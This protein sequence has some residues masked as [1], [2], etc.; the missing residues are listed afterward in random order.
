M[1]E[2][3]SSADDE[4]FLDALHEEV[5]ERLA[6][7]LPVDRDAIRARRPALGARIDD[8]VAL[9]CGVALTREPRSLRVAGYSIEGE[10]GRGAMGTVFLARQ[11]TLGRRVALKVLPTWAS[12]SES[13][14]QRFLQEARA[15]ARV[16]HPNVVA[17]HDVIDDGTVHAYAM[18]WI[19]GATLAGVIERLRA[20]GPEASIEDAAAVL[21]ADPARLGATLAVFLARVGAALAR[22]LAT[23]HAAGLLHRDVKPSNVLLRSD[24]APLLSDFGLVRDSETDGLT[25]TGQFLGTVAFASPEQLR[26]DA[27]RVDE[28]SDVYSLGVTLYEALARQLPYPGRSP[29]EVLGRIERGPAALLRRAGA[30]V[31]RDLETIVA[32]AIDP[33]PDRRYGSAADL[34]DDLERLLRLEPIRARPEGWLRRV[35]RVARRDR[36]ALAAAALAAALTLALAGLAAKSWL[37]RLAVPGRVASHVRSARLELLDPRYLFEVWGVIHGGWL[38]ARS[39]LADEGAARAIA[40]YEAALALDPDHDAARLERDLVRASRALDDPGAD[41]AAL[42]PPVAA[43]ARRWAAGELGRS[44]SLEGLA[45]SEVRALGVLAYLSGLVDVS[46]QALDTLDPVAHPDPLVDGL[47]GQVLVEAGGAAAAYPRCLRAAAA[48]PEAGFLAS[49]AAEAALASGDR[50]AARRLLD[51][52][53]RAAIAPDGRVHERRRLDLLWAEGDAEAAVA[54]YERMLR[55]GRSTPELFVRLAR[56]HES[57]GEREAAMRRAVEAH[58][59]SPSYPPLRALLDRV[60]GAWWS[61]EPPLAR[62]ALAASAIEGR[63]DARSISFAELARWLGPPPDPP[64]S[65]APPP[66]RRA[67]DLVAAPPWAP[68]ADAGAASRDG[69]FDDLPL[70]ETAARVSAAERGETLRADAWRALW[71]ETRTGRALAASLAAAG[72]IPRGPPQPPEGP[73]PADRMRE[74]A[75]TPGFEGVLLPAGDS[76]GDGIDELWTVHRRVGDAGREIR[77]TSLDGASARAGFAAALSASAGPV[78]LA[79]A[80]LD[81]DGALD[82]VAGERDA[83]EAGLDAGSV[84]CFSGRTGERLWRRTGAGA[85]TRL[86]LA[87]T[88]VGDVDGDGVPEIAVSSASTGGTGLVEILS[89]RDGSRL[90]ALSG[91]SS[92]SGFGAALCGPGDVDG[93]G[94]GDLA[95]SAPSEPVDGL[96]RGRV[97]V[98]SARDGKVLSVFARRDGPPGQLGH[99]LSA[100]GDVDGDGRGDVAVG[101]PGAIAGDGVCVV[102][103]RGEL[104]A[105]VRAGPRD[106]GL[107]SAIALSESDAGPALAVSAP[108]ADRPW[109][110]DAGLVLLVDRRSGRPIERAMGGAPGTRLGEGLAAIRVDAGERVLVLG[111]RTSDG[112]KGLWSW[113]PAR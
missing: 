75:V 22:A 45:P 24:G 43:V 84:A 55:E 105:T 78:R 97:R 65:A 3:G 85:D 100:V 15:L 42:P 109:A 36:R 30:R 46:I 102:S 26:G 51:A 9:A 34:A 33:D 11:E 88:V 52:A 48:F 77:V 96:P 63:G 86:G 71:R 80:D 2:A 62:F 93:D 101:A 67:W 60:S 72:W 69:E 5:L 59:G 13:A 41:F 106:G 74:I 21:G 92:L 56:S 47:L 91:E 76:D 20:R 35:A 38:R 19:E 49:A 87:V 64:T 73:R 103:S 81:G 29:A 58:R 6:E 16:R 90:R 54:G 12:L 7:G 37:D 44:V 32:K 113:R 95:V 27:D 39:L 111:G 61:H 23:V 83:A 10:L 108:E 4:S 82:V 112:S 94:A 8:V 68:P 31:P 66:S 28:R 40:E 99:A 79:T 18:E 14:T 50:A 57:R 53:E 1:K 25:R 89:G 70:A 110:A 107:G 104:L 17:V 98:V